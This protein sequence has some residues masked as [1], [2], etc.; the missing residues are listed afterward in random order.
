MTEGALRLRGSSSR[1][2][3]IPIRRRRTQRHAPGSV[4]TVHVRFQRA[5]VDRQG[6]DDDDDHHRGAQLQQVEPCF[7]SS[8][9]LGLR[10][11]ARN[12]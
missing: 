6:H 11:L 7:S 8:N 10:L 1:A 12:S 2:Y 9:L 3:G 5:V 4:A